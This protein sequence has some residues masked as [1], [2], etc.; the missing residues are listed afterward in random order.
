[1]SDN[2]KR[3]CAI[4][5]ALK[6]LCPQE[7]QGNHRRHL[8]TLAALMNGI[9]GSKRCNLPAIASYMPSSVQR[10]SQIKRYKRWLINERVTPEVYFLPFAA[11]LVASLP[12]G[13]LLLVMDAS[14]VGRGCL[15]LVVSV[16]YGKRALP[17][18]WLVVKSKKGHLSEAKHCELLEKVRPLIP[19]GRVV[20]FLGDGEFDGCGLLSCLEAYGWQYVCRTAKNIQMCEAGGWFCFAELG[21]EKGRLIE[22]ADVLFTQAGY[23]PVLAVAVWERAYKEP[24]FLVSNL[25][26]GQEALYWYKK[27][28]QIETFFSD[29]KSRG[30]YLSKCH[31]GDPDRLCRLMMATCLAYLWLVWLGAKVQR[32]SLWMQQIHRKRR[33]DLSLFQLGIAW[34]QHCLNQGYNIPVGFQFSKL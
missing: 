11:V 34:M 18:A 32:N 27:R 3:Y 5:D 17:L 20:I 8:Q 9:V 16:L 28:Y 22:I 24:M 15:A 31:L 13:P 21:M 23:G 4:R 2:L 30:F 29:Q 6:Q 19:A 26:L 14:E 12:P 7:P 1:M 25:E 33:C 10:E